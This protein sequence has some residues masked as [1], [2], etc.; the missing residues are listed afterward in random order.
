MEGSER[1][2]PGQVGL[3][4]PEMKDTSMERVGQ[5][6]SKVIDQLNGQLDPATWHSHVESPQTSPRTGSPGMPRR[7]RHFATLEGFPGPNGL[8]PLYRRESKYCYIRW[9]PP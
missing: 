2:E 9:R 6:L 4:I 1:S 7:G 5:P 8:L 3:L